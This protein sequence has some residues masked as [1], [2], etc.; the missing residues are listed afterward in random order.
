MP[1]APW[2]N[3]LVENS[4][5]HLNTFVRTVLDSQYDTWSQKVKVF[6]FALKSQVRTNMNLSPYELVFGQKS[7]KPIIFN[8]SSTTDSLGNCKP[9]ENSP[10]YPLPNHTHTDYLGHHPQI[11]R[12]QKLFFAHWFFNRAKI[13]SEVYNEVHS[14]LNRNKYSRTFINRRFG[15][16]QP[17]KINTYDLVVNKA[18]QI[19]VS[20]KIQ[21]Q[22]IGPYKIFDTPTLVT[23]KLENFFGKQITRHKSNILPYYPKELFVQE[24]MEKYFSDNS[25]LKLHKCTIHK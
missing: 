8:I 23:Y 15:T 19:G 17:L 24:Q 3:G 21:P 6:P 16:A 22:K 2:S 14:Y 5:R 13:H 25:L 10:C 18:T 12:L 20:K 1:Y 4:N 9:T 11:K 7:K